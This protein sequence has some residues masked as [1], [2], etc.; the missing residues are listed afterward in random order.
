MPLLI[1]VTDLSNLY[2]SFGV[3]R[4]HGNVCTWAYTGDSYCAAQE[5]GNGIISVDLE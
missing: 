5:W 1:Y 4:V 3:V 2:I